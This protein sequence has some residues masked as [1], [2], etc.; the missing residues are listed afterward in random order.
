[1]LVRAPFVEA[2]QHGSIRIQDL[3]EVMMARR[4]LRLAEERLIPFEAARNVAYADDCPCAFHSISAALSAHI[5]IAISG[6]ITIL[7]YADALSRDLLLS[8]FHDRTESRL[9]GI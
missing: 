6:E 1:M 7:G 8:G 2:E 3:T 4:R 5:L 9:E